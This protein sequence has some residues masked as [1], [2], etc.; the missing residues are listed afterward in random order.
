MFSPEP[1]KE[2]INYYTQQQK[3]IQI[4]MSKENFPVTVIRGIEYV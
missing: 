1:E 4:H 3:D 2:H